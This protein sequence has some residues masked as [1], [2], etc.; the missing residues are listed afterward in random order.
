MLENL[1]AEALAVTSD[2]LEMTA[3]LLE[4]AEASTDELTP[5][6]RQRLNLVHMGLAMAMQ[7]LDCEELQHLIA[8]SEV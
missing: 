6:A 3:M 7:A 1:L 8:Q 5:E 2:N 4:C